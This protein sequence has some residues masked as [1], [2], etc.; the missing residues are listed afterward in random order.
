MDHK[1]VG[2]GDVLW[3]C[4]PEGRK[5]G[6]APANFAYYMSQFGYDSLLV[7]AVGNDPLGKEI[8]DVLNKKSLDHFLEYPGYP[9]GT[10]KIEV[11]DKG[12]PEYE[13]VEDVAYDYI[14]YTSR[15]DAIA[16]KCTVACFG[17]M[18][19]RN[20]V[21][22]NTIRKFLESMPQTED[23]WKVFDINLRQNFY[24]KE[25]IEESL[26]LCN[27][28]KI[29]DEEF[30]T[31]KKMFGYA[32]ESYE[33]TCR[34]IISDWNLKF[35]ILTCGTRGSYI[36]TSTDESFMETPEVEVAD[37]VGAGD[38]FIA[39]FMAWI[40][41][42]ATIRDAHEQAVKVSAYVCTQFG[43]MCEIQ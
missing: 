11:D 14:P 30:E 37:T 39:T 16:R 1:I 10:V 15:L 38:S 40:L 5:I 19:Q 24:D 23:T 43:G 35:L 13:I 12:V 3:D 9:T 31:V 33:E 42:G 34:K 6:G 26:R 21:S 25:I 29:N 17:S 8:T 27:V 32:G 7:S 22:R 18:T 2:I 4:L 36:Y 28:F 41:K 20:P